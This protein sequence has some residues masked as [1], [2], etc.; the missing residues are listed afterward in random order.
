MLGSGT[1]SDHDA[2][3][4]ALVFYGM[5]LSQLRNHPLG[6]RIRGRTWSSFHYLWTLLRAWSRPSC[7]RRSQ[8]ISS[9]IEPITAQEKDKKNAND[10]A[11]L[12]AFIPINWIA[13]KTP[14]SFAFDFSQR[15]SYKLYTT[16]P[17]DLR[18]RLSV[19]HSRRLITTSHDS[20]I[21]R[22]QSGIC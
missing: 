9:T 10:K 19:C 17:D 18:D 7:C 11:Q 20:I 2:I 21:L 22:P 14:E 3:G 1:A 6:G 12:A 8:N 13:L 5:G 16:Q 4:Q 15:L